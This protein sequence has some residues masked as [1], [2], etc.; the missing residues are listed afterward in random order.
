[1]GLPALTKLSKLKQ[2]AKQAEE[3]EDY[4]GLTI[5]NGS[6]FLVYIADGMTPWDITDTII[7]ESVHVFHAVAKYIGEHTP[8]EEFQAYTTAHIA[9][10]L[11]KEY[12]ALHE[13][14]E[15]RLQAREQ[16]VQLEAGTNQSTVGTDSDAE[17][18]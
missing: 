6:Q 3:F 11:L 8:G 9:S 12:H 14:R 2:T 16:A 10:T 1:M 13:G 7:H 4:R 18:V 17:A 5:L 15:A